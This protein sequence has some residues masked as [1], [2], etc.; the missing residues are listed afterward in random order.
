M[1]YLSHLGVLAQVFYHLQGILRVALYAQRQRL[2][3]LQEYPGIEWGDGGTCIA[4][5]HGTDAGYE[6]CRTSHIGKYCTM[7]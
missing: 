2:R 6:C 3:A 5:Q 7:I 1:V 4:K